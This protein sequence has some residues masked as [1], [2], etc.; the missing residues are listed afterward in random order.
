VQR[1]ILFL[2]IFL[3][4]LIILG[5][6]FI[7][8]EI[9]ISKTIEPF[10]IEI[11]DKSGITNVVDPSTKAG[12]SA[13][14][15]LNSHFVV[16]YVRA[17]ETYNLADYQYNYDTIVR[18]FS[19]YRVYSSFKTF[20]NNSSQ[21][22]VKLYGNNSFTALK[23]RSVQYFNANEQAPGSGDAKTAQVRFSVLVDGKDDHKVNKIAN[24][25]FT[26][27]KSEYKQE[28]RFINPLGFTVIEYRVD[29]ENI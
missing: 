18:L 2:F 29:D 13:D 11:E 10:I 28:E 21:S 16:Q 12:L 24:I 14:E 20:I 17:R 26:Y 7:V 25:K 22:P 6:V 1:N 8:G 15:A 23:I 27:S 5:G 4:M 9:A 3:A 19:Q